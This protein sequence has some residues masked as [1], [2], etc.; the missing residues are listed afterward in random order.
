MKYKTERFQ[1]AEVNQDLL[2]FATPNKDYLLSSKDFT[3]KYRP[4]VKVY[5]YIFRNLKPQIEDLQVSVNGV[6]IGSIKKGSAARVQKLL[7]DPEYS[8]AELEI[9]GGRYQTFALDDNG[10]LKV[11]KLSERFWAHITIYKKTA[12]GILNRLFAK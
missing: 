11:Q 9:G 7:S 1:L 3:K 12:S 6:R 8:H 5:E 4:G 10:N 2:K